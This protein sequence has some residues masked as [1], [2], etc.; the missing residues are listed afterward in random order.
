MQ[1]LQQG[2][3]EKALAA[4]EKLLPDSA[5]RAEERCQMYIATCQRQMEKP[6]LTFLHA[7][8]AL[9][10]RH[11]AVEHRLLRGGA[12]AVQRHPR[13][14]IPRRTTLIMGWRCWTRSPGAAQE[15]LDNLARAIELNPKN[16]LQARVDND[17]QNMVDDPRFT[18]LLYPEIP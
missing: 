6:S 10:L 18:E 3:Y 1:L 5:A 7:G 8:R 16:R 17:F 9:R 13:A 12:R 4:L 14:L 11:L 15:C 2:K